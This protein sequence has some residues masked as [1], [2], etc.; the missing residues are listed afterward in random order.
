M[1]Y[2]LSSWKE[3]LSL[4]SPKNAKLFI[5]VTIKTILQSYKLILKHLWWLLLLSTALDIVYA[6]YFDIQSYF[7]LL[8]LFS[9]FLTIFFMYLIIRPSMKQKG[10]GYY[11]DYI[12]Y[13]I[14]FILLTIITSLLF[15]LL[16]LPIRFL[17]T[18][19]FWPHQFIFAYIYG[20]LITSILLLLPHNLVP[21]YVS[22][23]LTFMILFMLDS[24]GKI[25]SFLRSIIRGI[26]MAFY[27]YPF[28]LILFALFTLVSFLVQLSIYW[29]F[30]PESMFHSPLFSTLILPIPLSIWTNFYTKRL[31]DQFGLYYPETIKD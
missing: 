25:M 31:H 7:V 4:F 19:F 30:G 26:K 13:F 21:L 11:K 18:Q 9:W 23:L 24:D 20:L 2:L 17:I 3:S 14:Y 12:K 29:L 5:L 6:R 8:P 1:A 15:Y 27:N 10:F 16:P 28:C 22:P